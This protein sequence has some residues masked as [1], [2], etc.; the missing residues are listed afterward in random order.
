MVM[1]NIY[2]IDRKYDAAEAYID[3]AVP[4]LS[5]RWLSQSTD[6]AYGRCAYP[7]TW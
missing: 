5:N 2:I 1:G 6:V 4:V 7:K 3:R